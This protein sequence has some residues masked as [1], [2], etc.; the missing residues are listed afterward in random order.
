MGCVGR[1]EGAVRQLCMVRFRAAK[2]TK[3]DLVLPAR[4]GAAGLVGNPAPDW[5]GW[6]LPASEGQ[7]PANRQAGCFPGRFPEY[8]GAAPLISISPSS[9]MK[10]SPKHWYVVTFPFRFLQHQKTFPTPPTP[11]SFHFPAQAVGQ[12]RRE[13]GLRVSSS[14]ALLGSPA[15]MQQG[16]GAQP[17]LHSPIYPLVLGLVLKNSC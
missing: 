13:M 3:G 12:P 11:A 14:R 8:V 9:H 2:P 6:F 15:V 17:M 5:G 1:G 10:A 7:A 16:A 4:V